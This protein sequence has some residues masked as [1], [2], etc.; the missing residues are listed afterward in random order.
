MIISIPVFLTAIST[1]IQALT[2]ILAAIACN[3]RA[4]PTH[5]LQ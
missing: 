4:S 2:V 5:F 3:S 1:Y